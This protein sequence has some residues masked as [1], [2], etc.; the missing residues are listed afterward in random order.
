[1]FGAAIL[2]NSPAGKIFQGEVLRQVVSVNGDNN[3]DTY[4]SFI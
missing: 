3:N 2:D 1:M 4:F